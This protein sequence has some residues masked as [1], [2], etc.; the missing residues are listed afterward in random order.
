MNPL[1]R[2]ADTT[3]R[4]T[5]P[6]AA[7]ENVA[8]RGYSVG[9]IGATGAV[10]QK[11]LQVLSERNLPVRSLVPYASDRSKGTRLAF[12]EQEIQCD[13]LTRESIDGLDLVFSAA[14]SSVITQWEEALREANVTVIDKS[15]A[16]RLRGDVPLV[17]PE[18]NAHVLTK[19]HPIIASPNC[20]TIQLVV[21]LAPIHAEVGI[22]RIVVSTYQSV[23]GTGDEAVAELESQTPM[24][25]RG[26]QPRPEVYPHQIAFNVL[27]QV[28]TFGEGEAYTTEEQ[29]IVAETRR[30]LDAGDELGISATCARVPVFVGHSES[31]N[32]QTTKPLSAV[33]CRELLS[34]APS[35]AVVDAPGEGL[36]PL[37]I[38]AEGQ[39]EVLVGRIRD[40]ESRE[41]CLNLWVVGDNLRKG[42]ATNAVQIAE[43]LHERALIRPVGVS[44]S[45]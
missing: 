6:T 38:D 13:V 18:V 27:P 4:P 32:I 45:A 26:G 44:A 24:A 29:K 3:S 9:V 30:I 41:N 40:D 20:S 15:S 31:I 19:G 16:F 2:E 7:S 25:L 28:E 21:A 35:V 5:S 37:P 8:R 34:E 42:A 43:L 12:G 14:G 36:Y 1:L 39:D 11:V 10:G 23:S 33:Q 22:E 17:V